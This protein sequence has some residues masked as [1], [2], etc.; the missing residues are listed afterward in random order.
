VPLRGGRRGTLLLSPLLTRCSRLLLAALLMTAALPAAAQIVNG[1]FENGGAPLNGWTLGPGSSVEALQFDDFGADTIPV[2]DGNW[3]ALIC[4]GPDNL[5]GTP[6]GDYDANGTTDN[7]VSTLSTTFTT[8]TDNESLSFEW[9]FLTDDVGPGGQGQALYD[10]LF[11]ITIDG[12]SIV[13]GSVRKP[14]GSSPWADTDPYDSTHYSV[15]SP[16]PT[17]NSEFGTGAGG[18][19]TPFHGVCLTIADAGTY[20]LQFLVADQGDESYDSA[21]LVDNVQ[22]GGPCEPMLQITSSAGST[23]EAKG[24]ALVVTLVDNGRVVAS[25]DGST[26]AFRSDGDYTGDN[27]NL[28]DQLWIA[29]RNGGLYDVSR[30]TTSV[31]AVQGT[32]DI[33][34]NGQWLAFTSTGDLVPGGNIDGNFEVFRFSRAAGTFLQ[35]TDTAGC[36]NDDPSINDDGSR[37]AF[38]SDCGFGI[39]ADATT[40]VVLWEA[41]PT[42]GF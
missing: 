21:L 6:S 26:L 13:R 34:S 14:N 1:S 36:T 2:P 8:V 33:S 42:P 20:E 10:D 22:I 7:D 29:T 35:V 9:A 31:D 28:Q 3:F 38:V 15:N 40:E 17:D 4:S 5:S 37:I 41:T 12:I 18:G 24:G 27:P 11:D 32:P 23:V 39:S 16:G 30:V 25:D 19:R